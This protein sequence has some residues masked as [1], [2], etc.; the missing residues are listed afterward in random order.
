[1]RLADFNKKFFSCKELIL[2]FALFFLPGIIAPPKVSGNE[3][4]RPDFLSLVIVTG[5][6]E[7]GMI[8]YLVTHIGGRKLADYNVRPLRPMNLLFGLLSGIIIFPLLLSAAYFLILVLHSFPVNWAAGM[9]GFR[10]SYT[11]YSLLPFTLAACLVTGYSEELYFRCYL[12]TEFFRLGM[13]PAAAMILPVF[14]FG[15]GHFYQGGLGFA[16]A[17]VLGLYLT[18]VLRAAKNLH[19]P[20]IAHGIYNFC[21]LLLSGADIS[22]FD[23]IFYI[24]R[25][26]L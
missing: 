8:L 13:P 17:S 4:N 26:V 16:V 14:I 6:A 22:R 21:V 1:M 9:A 7:L 20:A 25:R 15:T 19:V 3:F 18:G 12:P 10:W 2:T 23:D 24:V 11:N 5:L